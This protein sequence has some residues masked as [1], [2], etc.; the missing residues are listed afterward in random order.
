MQEGARFA[1]RVQEAALAAAVGGE[2]GSED[3]QQR[4]EDVVAKEVKY[5]VNR[6]RV[7][8]DQGQR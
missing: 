1:R 2:E 6:E 4:V 7:V 8:D 3:L 5:G